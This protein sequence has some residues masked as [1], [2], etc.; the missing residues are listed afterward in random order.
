MPYFTQTPYLTRALSV[1]LKVVISSYFNNAIKTDTAAPS[2]TTT[3]QLAIQSSSQSHP[4]PTKKQWESMVGNSFN[5]YVMMLQTLLSQ[6]HIIPNTQTRIRSEILLKLYDTSRYYLDYIK[7]EY[8]LQIELLF[9]QSQRQLSLIH[10]AI[11]GWNKLKCFF[12]PSTFGSIGHATTLH[13]YNMHTSSPTHVGN[14]W[15]ER[16]DPL[17]RPW[18]SLT[19]PYFNE[20]MSSGSRYD[21]FAWLAQNTKGSSLPSVTYLS[22]EQRFFHLCIFGSHRLIYQPKIPSARRSS[23][24]PISIFSTQGCH[25][26]NSRNT[27]MWVCTTQGIFYSSTQR[28]NALHHSSLSSGHSVLAAGEWIVSS[29]KILLIS[30]QTGHY[31]CSLFQLL[32]ALNL[33]NP[34]IDLSD[35]VLH[36]KDYTTQ[37]QRFFYASEFMKHNGDIRR[38]TDILSA[39]G[40]VENMEIKASNLCAMGLTW[41]KRHPTTGATISYSPTFLLSSLKTID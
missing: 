27:C 5:R 18:G 10:S 21:F 16:A 28:V 22:P 30:N 34:K 4:L 23:D 39:I 25:T 29:G 17:H 32:R 37:Q 12:A 35:T 41:P 2:S 9:N 19:T 1:E 7:G 36:Y 40:L 38:C 11:T 24:I 33:L 6:Y 20:W 3:Q 14:Y 26:V 15:L 31:S 8:S 13:H